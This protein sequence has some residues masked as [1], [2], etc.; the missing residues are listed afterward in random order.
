MLCVGK[1]YTRYL[2]AGAALHRPPP[3]STIGRF[4]DGP[5]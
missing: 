3:F 1:K 5:S 4:E 2:R